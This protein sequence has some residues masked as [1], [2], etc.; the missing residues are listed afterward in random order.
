M[1]EPITMSDNEIRVPDGVPSMC[2]VCGA[3]S[4]APDTEVSTLLAVCNVLVLK[5][6][7]Q[8]GRRTVRDGKEA[9]REH[10]YQR[11]RDTGQPW[12]LAHTVWPPPEEAV[13][14]VLRDAWDVIPALL[15]QDECGV[16]V[17]QARD[18][19][20]EYVRDLAITGT[21]HTIGELAYRFTDRLGLPV[22]LHDD[23]VADA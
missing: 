1:T 16:T 12:Y 15:A 6:L 13:T 21:A 18:M 2:P 3:Y 8:V 9:R 20:D 4:L 23:E 22:V 19:L 17:R 14:K 5:A 7:E 10:R 11:Y